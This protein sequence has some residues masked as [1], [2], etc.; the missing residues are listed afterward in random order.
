MSVMERRKVEDGKLAG[1]LKSHRYD[2]A[3]GTLEVEFQDGRFMVHANVP[4]SLYGQLCQAGQP[5]AF[6]AVAI[7]QARGNDYAGP[8]LYP[9]IRAGVR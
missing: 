5:A 4:G 3:N 7:R 9:V 6:W 2:E 8:L 1:V